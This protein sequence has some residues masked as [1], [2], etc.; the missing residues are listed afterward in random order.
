MARIIL[1]TL[2]TA[3]VIFIIIVSTL[4]MVHNSSAIAVERERV[5]ILERRLA[6]QGVQLDA[7][8]RQLKALRRELY[9]QE[10]T[11]L[12]PRSGE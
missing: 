6:L 3:A 12:A 1:W 9:M 2:W 10:L 5:G 4:M 7:Q 11:V 8:E